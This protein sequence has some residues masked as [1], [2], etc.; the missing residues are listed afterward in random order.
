MRTSCRRASPPTSPIAVLD[1]REDMY[2][3]N[4]DLNGLLPNQ[5]SPFDDAMNI[6]I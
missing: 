4:S 1:I 6:D 3:R 2:A 5:L